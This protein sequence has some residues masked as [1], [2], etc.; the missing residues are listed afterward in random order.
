MSEVK[1]SH[2]KAMPSEALQTGCMMCAYQT[3]YEAA[4][5]WVD[6]VPDK[7]TKEWIRAVLVCRNATVEQIE[8]IVKWLKLLPQ[9]QR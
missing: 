4:T 6:L 2:D 3:G 1:C 9:P 8:K 7:E 5:K